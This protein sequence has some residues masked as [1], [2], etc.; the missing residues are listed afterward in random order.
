M[1]FVSK[2]SVASRL[3]EIRTVFLASYEAPTIAWVVDKPDPRLFEYGTELGFSSF[4]YEGGD[5]SVLCHAGRV[6][7]WHVELEQRHINAMIFC[8]NYDVSVIWVGE[9]P[10][11]LERLVHWLLDE[12][13]VEDLWGLIWRT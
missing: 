1:A 6:V 11:R 12:I 13:S 2:S 5:L 8:K 9:L 10:G 7:F 3:T 4:V